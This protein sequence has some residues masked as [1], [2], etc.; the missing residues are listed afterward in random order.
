MCICDVV[1]WP[2]DRR[3]PW[4]GWGYGVDVWCMA[5]L[6]NEHSK[7]F[8]LC[9]EVRERAKGGHLNCYRSFVKEHTQCQEVANLPSTTLTRL[10]AWHVLG[11]PV[12]PYFIT[13]ERPLRRVS[14]P[15]R[16]LFLPHQA[17]SRKS[18]DLTSRFSRVPLLGSPGARGVCNLWS[19]VGVYRGSRASDLTR[20]TFDV[21]RISSRHSGAHDLGNKQNVQHNC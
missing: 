20:A 6:L 10:C 4:R 7:P 18:A 11:F 19:Y 13:V 5:L 3:K 15:Q 2:G 14:I 1:G 12:Q 17:L 16:C 9:R 8:V 21:C